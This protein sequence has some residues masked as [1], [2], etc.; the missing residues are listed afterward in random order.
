M[1]NKAPVELRR[2]LY[3]L[4][5]LNKEGTKLILLDQLVKGKEKEEKRG[6]EGERGAES[7]L[8]Q[9]SYKHFTLIYITLLYLTLLYISAVP[10]N[11][12]QK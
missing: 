7:V 11:V 8:S 5:S 6:R 2:I 4:W 12:S 9:C 1:A 10:V 3:A